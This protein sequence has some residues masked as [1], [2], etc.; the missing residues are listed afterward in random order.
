MSQ[1]IGVI[2][3]CSSFVALIVMSFVQNV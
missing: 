1:V 3:L 2:I